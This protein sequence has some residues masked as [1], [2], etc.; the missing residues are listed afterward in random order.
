MYKKLECVLLIDDNCADNFI[1]SKLLKEGGY[2]DNI[3]VRGN[4]LDALY[5]LKAANGTHAYPSLIILDIN[6]PVMDGWEF[7]HEYTKLPAQDRK[8]YVVTM[9]T[10]SLSLKD[11][12]RASKYSDI[13]SYMTK[14]LSADALDRLIQ[15]NFPELFFSEQS[16]GA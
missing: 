3:V 8:T 7:L 9:L 11:K 1:H 16:G 10:S 2:T 14:P 13:H 6:M 5:Y 12:D 15:V 4:G